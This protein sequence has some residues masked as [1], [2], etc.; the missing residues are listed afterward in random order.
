MVPEDLLL[1]ATRCREENFLPGGRELELQSHGQ[2][3][4]GIPEISFP[5]GS[6]CVSIFSCSETLISPMCLLGT[7]ETPRCG[8]HPIGFRVVDVE[9]RQKQHVPGSQTL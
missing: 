6:G 5:I 1:A 7:P 4:D 2:S 3:I 8:F 9:N